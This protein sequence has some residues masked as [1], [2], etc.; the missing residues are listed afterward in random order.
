[1]LISF[2][3]KLCPKVTL[4]RRASRYKVASA[5]LWDGSSR[6]FSI[7]KSTLLTQIS[8]ISARVVSDLVGV[9]DNSDIADGRT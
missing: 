4:R 9:L 7:M 5:K 1:M 3:Q 6:L 2:Y 8:T